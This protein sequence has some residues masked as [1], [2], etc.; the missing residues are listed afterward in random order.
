G[1]GGRRSARPA[2]A[3]GDTFGVGLCITANGSLTT[4]PIRSRARVYLC[5]TKYG[6]RK[7][8]STCGGFRTEAGSPI[9][10]NQKSF[11]RIACN[12]YSL[13]R[14]FSTVAYHSIESNPVALSQ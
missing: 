3:E 13:A 8:G 11:P 4:S 5:P 6:A 12:E 14:P 2:E 1:G 10:S 9:S 7:S